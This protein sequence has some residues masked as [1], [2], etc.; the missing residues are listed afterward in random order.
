MGINRDSIMFDKDKYDKI[1]EHIDEYDIDEDIE[2]KDEIDDE[3]YE[4]IIAGKVN[5]FGGPK[6][7]EEMIKEYRER[8]RIK[9]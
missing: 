6:H 4:D 7:A 1:M 2:V 5:V 3:V 9:A 8:K